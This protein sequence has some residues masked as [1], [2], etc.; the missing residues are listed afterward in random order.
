[1]KLYAIVLLL[2]FTTLSTFSQSLDTA[3]QSVKYRC[4]GPFRGGALGGGKR[5]GE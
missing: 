3:F 2:L 4:I 1:M 5:C